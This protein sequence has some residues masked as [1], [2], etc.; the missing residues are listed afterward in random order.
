MNDEIKAVIL[1]GGSGTRLWPMSRQ[2][3]PKQ[4]LK[5]SGN[6]SM[7]GATISRL[8]PL[9]SA[10]DAWVVTSD[11]HASGEAFSE[12]E[13]LHQILEP[14][15]RNT[16]PAIAVT[17]AMM[18]DFSD[19]DPVMIVLP[20]DH[21]ISKH[22][23]FHQCL[24]TAVDLAQRDQLVTFGLLPDAPET[25][26]GYVQA[27]QGE[28]DVHKVLRFVEKPD[29]ATAEKMLDEGGYYWNSGMFVWKCSV[30]LK[31]LELYLP[32]VW[33]VLTKMR[34]RWQ[35]GEPW[36]EV[37]RDSFA[38][39]P[40]ISI[41][42][43]I[44]EKSTRVSLV[45][46]DIGWSDVGSWD[47]VYEVS[48]HDENGNSL[49][50]HVMAFDCENTLIRSE[51]RMIT[52]IGLEDM[53]VV[54]T[55]DAILLAKAGESQRVKEVVGELKKLHGS[56]HVQHMTVRRP[57][58]SY[59]VL[60]GA[61][62]GYQMKRIDVEPGQKLSLQSHQHRSEHWI[63]VAGTATVTC[64]ELVRIVPKNGSA[65]IPIGEV[66]RLEN[67]GKVLLQLIEVQVGDYL[68]ED[69]IERLEDVYGRI[70]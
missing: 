23:A 17:A 38:D 7:L 41:D 59:T 62:A 29:L 20:A 25:G 6:Q 60:N 40:D 47:A 4:F 64:G 19:A 32:E 33:D 5:L 43:G 39:M 69:D 53:I 31:E 16:A 61:S 51:G 65:Y 8:S 68:G 58:G 14:C 10:H 35:G 70:K 13:G 52:A 49:S 56:L 11:S 46:A 67:K 63:V 2:Q 55:A 66:H 42:Y 1:A 3:L 54:D 30:I 21:L 9:I 18:Y 36:Q 44:M 12:L 48:K 15:G 50:E 45:A 57:W 27:E 26:F 22:D 24:K 28:G 37:I 34:V